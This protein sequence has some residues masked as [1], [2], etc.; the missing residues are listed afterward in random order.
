MC[1]QHLDLI[2]RTWRTNNK[3]RRYVFFLSFLLRD[4]MKSA[5]VAGRSNLTTI[6]RRKWGSEEIFVLCAL[7]MV[8]RFLPAAAAA[9]RDGDSFV[10]VESSQLARLF[11]LRTHNNWCGRG[12]IFGTG[13]S[14]FLSWAQTPVAAAERIVP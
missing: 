3:P 11:L 5:A 2:R 13:P 1:T 10:K 6:K 12:S 4:M 9:P 7:R 8:Y 14:P